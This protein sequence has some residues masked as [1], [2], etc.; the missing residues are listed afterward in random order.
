[1]SYIDWLKSLKPGDKVVIETIT[2]GYVARKIA[3]LTKTQIVLDNCQKFYISSG[4][5]VGGS[6]FG[7][8]SIMP[9]VATAEIKEDIEKS[10]LIHKIS[11]SYL[12]SISI[13]SLRQILSIIESE[14]RP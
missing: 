8:T 2:G 1:M 12:H 13:D 3:R 10:T 9:V 11:K 5:L 7:R 4:L 6:A 14:T